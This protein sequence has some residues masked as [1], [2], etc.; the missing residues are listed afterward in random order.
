MKHISLCNERRVGLLNLEETHNIFETCIILSQ[1]TT[2]LFTCIAAE[3][4]LFIMHFN[5]DGKTET[6]KLVAGTF[7]YQ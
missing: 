1:I 3:N 5:V 4:L 7:M 2:L 6:V